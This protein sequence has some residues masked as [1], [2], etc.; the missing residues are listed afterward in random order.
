MILTGI[1]NCFI[2]EGRFENGV[3]FGAPIPTELTLILIDSMM[4]ALGFNLNLD[5]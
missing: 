2:S 4:P 5:Y 3:F 1:T